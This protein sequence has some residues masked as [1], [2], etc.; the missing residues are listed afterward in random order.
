MKDL[1]PKNIMEIVPYP[2]GKP[3]EELEREYGVKGSIKLASNENPLGPSPRALAA[4]RKNLKNINRYP[5]GS[6][7]YLKGKLSKNLG[8]DPENL[9]VGNG[10][11]EIIELAARAFLRP[12]E[13]AVMAKPSFAVYPIVTKATGGVSRQVPVRDDFSIDLERF[14]EALTEKTRLIFLDLPNNPIGTIV[15]KVELDSFLRRVPESCIVILDQAYREFVS[16]PD[17]PDGMD[18]LDNQANVI[19]LRTFSKVYGLAGLRVGYGAARPDIIDFMNRVRQPFNVNS[20]AQAAALGALE[21]TR[22]LEKTLANNRAGLKFLYAQ[23]KKLKLNYLESHSNFFMID[24]ER[25]CR[26]V[27]D[28]MLRLGV[29]VRPMASYGLSTWIRVNVGTPAE[30]RRFVSALGKVLGR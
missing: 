6:C 9:I 13:E 12:G 22:H 8:V 25:D 7:H 27:Y 24:L 30:N 17:F 2:P 18:Y 26:L 29:I 10:S 20:L 19:C 28:A 16:D 5:D 14:T 4:I 23:M 3:I 11:N 1:A 21:D 15:K